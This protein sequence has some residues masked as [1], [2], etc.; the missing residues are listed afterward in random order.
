MRRGGL[1]RAALH[2]GEL[3]ADRRRIDLAHEAPDVLQLATLS[4]VALDALRFEHPFKKFP[5]EIHLRQTR[6]GQRYER[7]A[8]RL[9]LEHF[10]FPAGLADEFVLHASY[11]SAPMPKNHGFTCKPGEL[12]ELAQSVLDQARRAGTAGCDCDVSESYGVSVTVRMGK[13]DTV[14]HNRD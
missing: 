2:R 6:F 11:H 3:L 5:L 8:H 12:R 14:E 10:A 7:C 9:Q 4:L 1:R 13:P